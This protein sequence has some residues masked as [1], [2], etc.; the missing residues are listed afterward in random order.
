MTFLMLRLIQEDQG[1]DKVDLR[2]KVGLVFE[3]L[4]WNI[5]NSFELISEIAEKLIF[6]ALGG[7]N[8]K[9]KVEATKVLILSCL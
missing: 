8:S 3:I 1:V 6:A 4:Q 9:V 7:V 5:Q 2:K